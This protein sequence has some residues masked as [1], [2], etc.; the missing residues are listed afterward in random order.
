MQSTI[1]SNAKIADIVLTL[2]YI[3]LGQ[4]EL[5]R[6]AAMAKPHLKWGGHK[7]GVNSCLSPSVHPAFCVAWRATWIFAKVGA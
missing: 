6:V 7:K 3:S 2:W 4:W 5:G 1:V